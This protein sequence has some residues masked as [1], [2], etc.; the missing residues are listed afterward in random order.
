MHACFPC[1]LRNA[2]VLQARMVPRFG[3]EQGVREDG[4]TKVRAV[5][6]FTESKRNACTAPTEELMYDTL[7]AFFEVLKIAAE[8]LEADLEMFKADIDSAFR[9][10]PI[11]PSHREFAYIAFKYKGISHRC[12][13]TSLIISLTRSTNH[14]CLFLNI[15][16]KSET[17]RI[18]SWMFYIC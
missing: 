15:E 16:G 3:V 18:R 4:T 14:P 9:R 8:K 5:N 1:R 2:L 11:A 13:I 10:I 17:F 7:D 6:N 12:T